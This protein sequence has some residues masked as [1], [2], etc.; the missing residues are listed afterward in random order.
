MNIEPNTGDTTCVTLSMTNIQTLSK[1]ADMLT[2]GE[3]TWSDAYLVRNTQQGALAIVIE[4]DDKHYNRPEGG[5]GPA[6]EVLTWP[7]R[8]EIEGALAAQNPAPSETDPADQP[9]AVLP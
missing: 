4:P 2:K 5:P 6:A 1:Y 9:T 3:I 8:E 7:S